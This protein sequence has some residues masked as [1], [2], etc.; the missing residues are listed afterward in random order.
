MRAHA[1]HSTTMGILAKLDMSLY[2]LEFR[3]IVPGKRNVESQ[4]D[5]S[6]PLIKQQIRAR[7]KGLSSSTRTRRQRIVVAKPRVTR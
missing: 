6:A 4:T 3:R 7:A 2:Q 5:L 1:R